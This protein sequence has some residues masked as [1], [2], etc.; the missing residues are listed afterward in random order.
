MKKCV[1]VSAPVL[2]K[3]N[4]FNMSL[5]QCLSLCLRRQLKPNLS[6]VNISVQKG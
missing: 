5:K 4:G 3:Q 1:E 6:L 2:Q